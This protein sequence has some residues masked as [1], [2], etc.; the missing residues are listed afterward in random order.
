[1]SEWPSFGEDARRLFVTSGIAAAYIPV[2]FRA[3]PE[4]VAPTLTPPAGGLDGR[5]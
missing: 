5:N 1:V 2:R 4:S 3:P